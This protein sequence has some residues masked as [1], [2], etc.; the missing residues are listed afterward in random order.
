MKQN[1]WIYRLLERCKEEGY[2]HVSIS[3]EADGIGDVIAS[4]SQERNGQH[5]LGSILAEMKMTVDHG[6]CM[7]YNGKMADVCS[8]AVPH[9][10]FLRSLPLEF[11]ESCRDIRTMHQELEKLT[12]EIN[13]KQKKITDKCIKDW[14]D[15]SPKFA[16]INNRRNE[17][18]KNVAI[19][20][21]ENNKNRPK[22]L[23]GTEDF[24]LNKVVE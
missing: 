5:A 16:K 9:S 4:P 21:K 24:D 20:D 11:R 19:K 6:H 12:E 7:Q 18:S 1:S 23:Y 15:N 17:L 3:V 10:D 14:R 8:V 2:K 13:R 22:W